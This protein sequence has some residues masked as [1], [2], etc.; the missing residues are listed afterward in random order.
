MK[1]NINLDASF[2]LVDTPLLVDLILT[3]RRNELI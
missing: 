1:H 2:F 3:E